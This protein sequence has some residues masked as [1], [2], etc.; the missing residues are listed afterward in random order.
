MLKKI[1]LVA[2]FWPLLSLAD[3]PLQTVQVV[4]TRDAEWAGYRHAYKAH[5]MYAAYVRPYPLV[6]AHMQLRPA[7]PQTSMAGLRLQ[8][9]GTTGNI[10]IEVDTVGRALLPVSDQMYKEDALLRL[11]RG[12]GL[13]HFSGR[14]SIRERDDGVYAAD[15][16][17]AACEQLISV[18]RDAGARLRLL[19]KNCAGIKFV[20]DASMQAPG[21]MFRDASGAD[22]LTIPVTDGHAFEDQTM[23]IY[24]L[25][26]Y[27]FADWPREGVLLT[28]VKPVAIGTIYE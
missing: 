26:I 2:A 9:A 10:D 13:Y 6:Q 5:A 12:K 25:A 21:V 3:E 8:L 20:Y 27:R 19:R 15:Q 14:F 24:K 7:N 23:G 16:L 4:A 17:R 11:N 28:P 1:L 22:P 18:Q